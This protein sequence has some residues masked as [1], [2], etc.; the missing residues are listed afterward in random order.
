[1]TDLQF[2]SNSSNIASVEFLSGVTDEDGTVGELE[3]TFK[4]GRTYRYSE[5]PIEV[6][7]VMKAVEEQ[8]GSCGSHFNKTVRNVYE[9]EEVV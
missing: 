8:T 7:Q 5:V 9:C 2:D 6:F 1:M 4:S 3:V